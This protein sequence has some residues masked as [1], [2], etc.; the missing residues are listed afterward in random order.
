MTGHTPTAL[1]LGA[2]QAATSHTPATLVTYATTP[3]LCPYL[4][5][6]YRTLDRHRRDP[7][8]FDRNAALRLLRNNAR[9]AARSYC[10]LHRIPGPWRA[11]FDDAALD[12]LALALYAHWR[13]T[14]R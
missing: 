14:C 1:A 2:S 9:D 7:D 8:A 3:P 10:R 5:A 11:T 4:S 12:R 6:S 13:L